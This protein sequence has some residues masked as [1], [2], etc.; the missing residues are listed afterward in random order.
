MYVMMSECVFQCDYQ[1]CSFSLMRSS[2]CVQACPA[3]SA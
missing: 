1:S 2:S 3:V